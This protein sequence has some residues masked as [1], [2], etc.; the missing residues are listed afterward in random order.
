MDSAHLDEDPLEAANGGVTE[1]QTAAATIIDPEH[2]GYVE[3]EIDIEKVLRTEL[4]EVIAAIDLAPLTAA[5]VNSIPE[6]A[7]G[8]YVLFVD[9]YPVYAGKTD[10]RHGFRD[11]LNR[12]AFTIQNRRNLDPSKIA[13]KAIRILVFSNFDVEAI[14]IDAMRKADGKALAWNDSGFGSN[15]PGHNREGQQPADFDISYPI[16]ID[17]PLHL[18]RPGRYL[19]LLL[20]I[21]L[22]QHLPYDLRYETDLKP[23]T[24]D[25]YISYRKGHI[26]QRNA[27][28]IEVTDDDTTRTLLI[29]I[30]KA[31]P[32]GWRTTVFPGRVILYKEDRR[33]RYEME[34]FTA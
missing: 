29:K 14:L 18:V 33:Y 34:S 12:H 23:G 6:G 28:I 24:D 30:M 16:N 13:F 19:P 7:K 25:K 3:Y 32:V 2:K 11:R 4:P 8:A 26:D 1:S 27:E 22:K 10:T 31:L 21:A 20:L 9:G 17:R 15:D 5:A